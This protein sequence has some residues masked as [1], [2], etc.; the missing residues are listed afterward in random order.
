MN[1]RDGLEEERMR[2]EMKIPNQGTFETEGNSAQI[3][4]RPQT[5]ESIIDRLSICT[6]D[7]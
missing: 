5:N 3:T 4:M 1:R 6:K 7:S 2:G